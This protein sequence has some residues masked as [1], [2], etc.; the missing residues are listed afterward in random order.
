M[1][2]LFDIPSLSDYGR[3]IGLY[4]VFYNTSTSIK[5]TKYG[6]PCLRVNYHIT[7]LEIIYEV[8]KSLSYVDFLLKDLILKKLKPG[9]VL[10]CAPVNYVV[11]GDHRILAKL[12]SRSENS[13]F[14][15]KDVQIRCSYS[16]DRKSFGELSGFKCNAAHGR[17]DGNNSRIINYINKRFLLDIHA[18]VF[19]NWRDLRHD[20]VSTKVLSSWLLRRFPE[21]LGEY[22]GEKS[23]K[24]RRKQG[25]LKINK[26]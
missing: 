9:S 19:G 8:F 22:L 26:V 2:L 12:M 21:N 16:G 25:I 10:D 1:T 7:K 24:Q 18:G 5:K 6:I 13:K 14:D 20:Y 11:S 3:V 4:R 23:K 15:F 17:R